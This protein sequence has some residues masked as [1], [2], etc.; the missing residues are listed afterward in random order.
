MNSRKIK[1]A[2]TVGLLNSG[3]QQQNALQAIKDLMSSFK[4]EV[5]NFLGQA[6]LKNARLNRDHIV[7]TYAIRFERCT[8]N[9]DLIRNLATKTQVVQGFRLQ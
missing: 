3:S 9:V 5:G 8:L 7:E 1:L 2:L 6:R 4:D